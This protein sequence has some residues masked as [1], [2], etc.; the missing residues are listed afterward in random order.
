[1]L[2]VLASDTNLNP[3]ITTKKRVNPGFRK[4]PTQ[5][6]LPQARGKVKVEVTLI[7][8]FMGGQGEWVVSQKKFLNSV[9]PYHCFPQRME[10]VMC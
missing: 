4:C 9:N 2:V 3:V 6:S 8:R 5:P 10:T 1:M 7:L